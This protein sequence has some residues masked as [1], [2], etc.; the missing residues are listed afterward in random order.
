MKRIHI[1]NLFLALIVLFTACQNEN[2]PDKVDLSD[3]PAESKVIRTEMRLAQGE[4]PTL[5]SDFPAFSQLYFNRIMGIP[6]DTAAPSSIPEI[7]SFLAFETTRRLLDTVADVYPESHPVFDELV[8]A[9]RYYQY[10]FPLAPAP[11]FYTLVSEFSL[12]CFLFEDDERKNAVGISLELFLGPDFPYEKLDPGNPNF[13]YF[14]SRTFN[15]RSSSQESHA[16][17]G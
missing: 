9:A 13:S 15:P 8:E 14:L 6:A 17:P 11:D 2:S 16:T 1:I 3:I 10:Y 5:I 12:S 7:D 4:Y